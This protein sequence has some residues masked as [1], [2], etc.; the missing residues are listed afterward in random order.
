MVA[1]NQGAVKTEPIDNRYM[2]N[3]GGAYALPPL[4]GP[5]I[6]N[7]RTL[8]P[9]VP[10]MAQHLGG[11][12]GVLSFARP[13]MPTAVSM[14]AASGSRPAYTLPQPAA[15]GQPQRIPQVDGPASDSEDDESPSPPASYAPRSTHP[16][17]AQ[18]SAP[19][20]AVIDSEAINSDLDDS[21]TGS[22]DEQEEGAGG[23]NDIVFCTYDK[24][25]SSSA[26]LDQR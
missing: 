16:S 15:G 20:A 5:S 17:L 26:I 18:P 21:D 3:P 24:V 23:E 4:P 2:L 12:T 22:D 25:F 13:G 11:H 8:P 19:K 9:P 10:A 14:P 6:T 1:A 7:S